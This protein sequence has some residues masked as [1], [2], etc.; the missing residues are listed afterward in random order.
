MDTINSVRVENELGY[1]NRMRNRGN[2]SQAL[3]QRMRPKTPHP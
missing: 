1:D 2:A 3:D